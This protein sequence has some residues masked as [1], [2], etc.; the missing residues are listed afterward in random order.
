LDSNKIWAGGGVGHL[1]PKGYEEHI[2]EVTKAR[3]PPKKLTREER[4]KLLIPIIQG[5]EEWR[6]KWEAADFSTKDI[7]LILREYSAAEEL[8]GIPR[9]ELELDVIKFLSEAKKTKKGDKK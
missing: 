5:N 7:D 2:K 3:S 1:C 4:Q 8:S 6:K 9:R